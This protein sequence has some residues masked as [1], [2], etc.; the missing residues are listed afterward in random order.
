MKIMNRTE[1]LKLNN[2][3]YCEYQRCSFNEL[4]IK[5][6]TLGDNDFIYQQIADAIKANDSEEFIDILDRAEDTG[7]SIEMDLDCAGREGLFL[8]PHEQLYA[9]WEPSDVAKLIA[10]LQALL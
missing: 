2:V 4:Q 1:F 6:Q 7:E 8:E 9:V 3:L 10:K 5:H